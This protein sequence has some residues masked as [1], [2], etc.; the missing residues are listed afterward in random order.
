LFINCYLINFDHINFEKMEKIIHLK[1]KESFIVSV[2]MILF[3]ILAFV[4][5][6]LVL[7]L[8]SIFAML[9][10]IKKHAHVESTNMVTS[11]VGNSGK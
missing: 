8:R 6:V 3:G 2:F 9:S 4:P 1:G 11:K 7:I 5:F 10:D